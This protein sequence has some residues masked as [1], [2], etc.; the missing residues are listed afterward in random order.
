MSRV[1]VKQ[2]C[3]QSL[4]QGQDRSQTYSLGILASLPFSPF[5]SPPFCSPSFLCYPLPSSPLN[6]T[7]G[8][9]GN[10]SVPLVGTKL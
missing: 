1:S 2:K 9:G 5:P 6:P 3:F 7:S 10:V 4:H 8:S